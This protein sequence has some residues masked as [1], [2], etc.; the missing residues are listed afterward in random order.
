[1]VTAEEV[2]WVVAF[3]ASPRSIAIN[4]DAVACGGGAP[5]ALYYL[6]GTDANKT[7]LA[8]RADTRTKGE[9]SCPRRWKGSKRA[10]AA[11]WWPG[12]VAPQSSPIGERTSSRSSRS[13]EI[14][15]AASARI[16]P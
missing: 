13:S 14:P 9:E 1:F 8:R 10:S 12:G 15:S 3:L 16:S 5:R 11:A 7:T 4:G 6:R 2:A